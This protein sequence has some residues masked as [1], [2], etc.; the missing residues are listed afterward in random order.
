MGELNE[1]HRAKV[2]ARRVPADLLINAC[3]PRSLVDDDARNE[4]EYLPENIDM[5]TCWLGRMG[6]AWF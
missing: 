1:E 3:L 5:M 6:V 4:L 2:A